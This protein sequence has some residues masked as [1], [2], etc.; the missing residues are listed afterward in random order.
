M[1]V[2]SPDIDRHRAGTTILRGGEE[3]RRGGRVG[4][5][6]VEPLDFSPRLVGGRWQACGEESHEP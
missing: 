4:G 6:S 3:Q 5:G 2:A 1:W